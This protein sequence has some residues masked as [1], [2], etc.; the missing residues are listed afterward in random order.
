MAIRVRT[1][2][3]PLTAILVLDR[4]P[5][6]YGNDNQLDLIKMTPFSVVYSRFMAVAYITNS[7]IYVHHI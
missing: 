3:L 6:E 1:M 5:C 7:I 2:L 4:R